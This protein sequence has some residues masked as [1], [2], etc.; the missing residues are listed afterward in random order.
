MATK[1][2]PNASEEIPVDEISYEHAYQELEEIVGALET[3]ERTL[4][5]ALAL[6]TRGQAL[7][8]RCAALLDTAEL[9]VR[10]QPE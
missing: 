3:E 9:Q 10:D 2:Q 7:A 6:Y 5:E 1:K 8:Q 4:D